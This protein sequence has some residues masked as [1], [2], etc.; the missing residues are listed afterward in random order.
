MRFARE[1]V[2]FARIAGDARA[3]YV[4]PRGRSSA[5]AGH[6]V[7]EIEFATVETM[8]AVLAG[9]LVTLED[10]V[11]GKFHFLLRKPIESEK[12][13]DA[14]DANLKGNRR[15][16]FVIRRVGRQIAPALEIVRH[17]IVRLIGRN[18]VRVSGVNQRESATGGADIHRLPE[19][20]EYQNLTVEHAMQI[21]M[22]AG[23]YGLP[24][25]FARR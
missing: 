15:D 17:K 13:D 18:N 23:F 3:N 25:K 12:H 16:Q 8:T 5:I 20:V 24:R 6:D 11:S 10:V 2:A 1:P 9:V 4:L 19:P 7:I 14:G 22:E 21:C